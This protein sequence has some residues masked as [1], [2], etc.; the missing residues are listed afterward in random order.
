MAIKL[1]LILFAVA[2][3]QKVSCGGLTWQYHPTLAS[4]MIKADD[5]DVRNTCSAGG[6]IKCLDCETAK[7]C[8]AIGSDY[9]EADLETCA[10]GKT[11]KSGKGCVDADQ[12]D[13]C[14]QPERPNADTFI[15]ETVGIFPD[16]Y[17]CKT[18]HF[19]PP[20]VGNEDFSV[21][22]QHSHT[23]RMTIE[24]IK[25][26]ARV[27]RTKPTRISVQHKCDDGY[28]YDASTAMCSIKLD[29]DKKCPSSPSDLCKNVGDTKPLGIGSSYFY[30]CH[31]LNFG[32]NNVL[33]PRVYR[34]P[35]NEIFSKG[36][37]IPNDDEDDSNEVRLKNIAP[38]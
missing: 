17:D 3:V 8:I 5:G 38:L 34:C 23:E 20:Q 26:Q 1:A 29:D 28:A 10:P 27:D 32:T 37:C 18:Y 35:H 36:T 33:V 25:K 31:R 12:N 21:V 24:A 7:M 30:I 11:C 22:Y 9:L 4:F 2:L 16:L 19:C 14:P 13:E 6:Q 15:C